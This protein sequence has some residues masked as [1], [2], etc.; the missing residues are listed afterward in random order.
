MNFIQLN[1]E[2][3][4]QE[5]ICCAFADKKSEIAVKLKKEWLSRRIEEGLVFK[6]LDAR[7]K[8]FIEYLPVENC[9]L[10]VNAPNY[11]IINCL[12]VSGSYSGKGYAKELLSQCENESKDKNGIV[13]ISSD[14]KRPFLADKKFFLKNG[15]E[16]CDTAEPYFELFVKKF[17]SNAPNPSFM[18]NAKRGYFETDPGID[19]FYTVQCPF[20]TPY[21]EILKN[22]SISKFLIIR[23]HKIKNKKMAQN[24]FCAATTYSIFING[25]FFT[26]EILTEKKFINLLNSII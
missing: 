3:I 23:Y 15:F 4:H 12:W 8:V 13:V 26:H 20:T 2:N 10:P 17:N 1:Q 25:K 7:A 6:K 14:K 18:P 5:H 21:I 11:N 22:S 9:W 24:H 16:V 19:I